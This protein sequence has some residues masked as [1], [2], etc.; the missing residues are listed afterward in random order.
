VM[1]T[2]AAL[3]KLMHWPGFN[4]IVLISCG[5]L[6]FIFLPFYLYSGIKNPITKFNTIIV[7]FLL[8]AG[9]GIVLTLSE[10]RPELILEHSS[11]YADANLWYTVNSLQESN[12]AKYE[13]LLEDSLYTKKDKLK[14][15]HSLFLKI[16]NECDSIATR[17]AKFDYA[18]PGAKFGTKRDSVWKDYACSA[19]WEQTTRFLFDKQS[20]AK[21][22]IGYGRGLKPTY[23]AD[24]AVEAGVIVGWDV[25]YRS[26]RLEKI[27]KTFDNLRIV[28]Q[29]DFN[30]HY[31]PHITHNFSM[32]STDSTWAMNTFYH[33]SQSTV[34]KNLTLIQL[35]AC[36]IESQV[37]VQR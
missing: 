30:C 4:L 18:G 12:R 33:V 10:Q 17:L 31:S 25:V 13:S 9:A 11:I 7:T 34:M 22:I 27:K 28:A 29:K 15:V 23:T 8:A 24:E 20:S 26:E 3:T 14:S 6:L 32:H 19:E 37:L 35:E 36:L 2:Y 21:P 5:L 16:F 1:S